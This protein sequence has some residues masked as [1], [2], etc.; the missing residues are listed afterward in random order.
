MVKDGNT[1]GKLDRSFKRRLDCEIKD[2]QVIAVYRRFLRDHLFPQ[3]RAAFHFLPV[4]VE[5]FLVA[6]YDGEDQAFFKPHRD[7]TTPGTAHRRFACTINLNAEHYSGGDL[8]FPEYGATTYRA[9]TGG[10]VVFSGSLLH[11]VAPVTSGQRYAT[12]PF[13]HD[14]AAERIRKQNASTLTGEVIHAED[15]PTAVAA[16]A[17]SDVRL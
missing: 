15:S 3:M 6:C 9:P 2:P 10:A 12:L 17:R 1:V 11:E 7:N 4:H 16:A 14:A 5:R 13:I 8:R